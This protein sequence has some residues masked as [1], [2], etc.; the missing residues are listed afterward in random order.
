MIDEGDA[1]NRQPG[2]WQRFAST[3]RFL[4]TKPISAIG[5]FVAFLAA[6]VGIIVG[7]KE[8]I[9]P[10]QKS[11]VERVQSLSLGSDIDAVERSLG[12][13]NRL[14]TYP[15]ESGSYRSGPE[16]PTKGL[17]VRIYRLDRIF[18]QIGYQPVSG[19]VVEWVVQ[20]CNPEVKI[21]LPRV[22]GD[23]TRVTLNQSTLGEV[24][25]DLPER[26]SYSSP[27]DGAHERL[28][29][30]Q[31][32]VASSNTGEV[33]GTNHGRCDSQWRGRYDEPVLE[34]NGGS[35][36]ATR[37]SKS[38]EVPSSELQDFRS[39]KVVNLYGQARPV[40]GVEEFPLLPGHGTP[41]EI[42]GEYLPM[43]RS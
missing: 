7:V 24:S 33:W 15:G 10:P 6:I 16:G 27:A 29:F 11:P 18:V 3:K 43:P 36:K 9:P 38:E 23:N 1:E 34:W 41:V 39:N 32:S 12:V 40:N 31:P 42:T 37:S 17:S 20:S 8:L 25:S 19:T 21:Q 4:P 14:I 5:A 13:K 2:R 28:E 30:S 26:A 22:S 35:Q